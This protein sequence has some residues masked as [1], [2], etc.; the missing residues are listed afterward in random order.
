MKNILVKCH[1]LNI[2]G[3]SGN[4][5][6]ISL[7]NSVVSR[8]YDR[9]LLLLNIDVDKVDEN[10][11]TALS[12][13]SHNG[14]KDICELLLE[15]GADISITNL[16]NWSPFHYA[17]IGGHADI[18]KLLLQHGQ[19]INE[20]TIENYTSLHFACTFGHVDVCKTL[21]H[22]GGADIT[23]RTT[24]GFAPIHIV[25]RSGKSEVC[26]LLLEYNSSII[27]IQNNHGQSCIILAA[28]NG[29]IDT[30]KILLK[31]K[32]DISFL[33]I[34]SYTALHYACQSDFSE[35]CDLLLDYNSSIINIQNNHGQTCIILAAEFDHIHTCRMLLKYNPNI[36]IG[37][38]NDW[39]PLH[40]ASQNGNAQI[41]EMLIQYDPGIIDQLSADG[42]SAVNYACEGSNTD[43]FN[44]LFD[45]GANLEIIDNNGHFPIHSAC[46]NGL[47]EVCSRLV[48]H[49][50]VDICSEGTFN[51]TPLYIASDKSNLELCK[52][53]LYHGA[54]VDKTVTGMTPLYAASKRGNI[55]VCKILLT[56]G[57]NCNFDCDN[58]YTP[59]L[60]ALEN[61]HFEICTMMKNTFNCIP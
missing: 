32:P 42:N 46:I 15:K 45:S 55:E 40:Y 23:I 24:D 61:G 3:V 11:R 26:N 57:A 49:I 16:H 19:L 9:L 8:D 48:K 41:C 1:H 28:D 18:C 43:V 50:D 58:G 2:N 37:C 53:F 31:Y 54:T 17:G 13:A 44:I 29:H 25:S 33:D 35:V 21:L 59:Y 56:N 14:Y 36:S 34:H 20:L 10:K 52:L 5:L 22:Y 47:F 51:T 12:M 27:N 30:C 39:T 4:N 60:I 7:I 38:E 6:D